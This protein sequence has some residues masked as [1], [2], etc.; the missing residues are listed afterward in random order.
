MPLGITNYGSLG[1]VTLI[2][3]DVKGNIFGR[4]GEYWDRGLE[5]KTALYIDPNEERTDRWLSLNRLQLP[6]GLSTYGS[7]GRVSL[8]ERDV[9]GNISAEPENSGTEDWKKKLLGLELEEENER[10]TQK[11]SGRAAKKTE[12]QTAEQTL[13][14]SDRATIDAYGRKINLTLSQNRRGTWGAAYSVQSD[15]GG[16]RI[17]TGRKGIDPNNIM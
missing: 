2:E 16:H 12:Q 4:D 3:R 15:G 11:Q 17:Q 1:R 7:V 8:I 13:A 5:E 6:L 14:D 10:T 9:K